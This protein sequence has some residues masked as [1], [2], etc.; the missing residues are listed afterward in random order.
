MFL[1]S[2]SMVAAILT[3]LPLISGFRVGQWI[4]TARWLTS[5]LSSILRF[6]CRTRSSSLVRWIS[7]FARQTGHVPWFR[8][9]L[10]N[11][12]DFVYGF[13][14]VR[15]ISSPHKIRSSSHSKAGHS[16]E[17][18]QSISESCE[19][20]SS[21]RQSKSNSRRSFSGGQVVHSARR[22]RSVGMAV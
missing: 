1:P 11:R 7:R 12:F 4:K 13:F 16:S 5:L 9:V 10:S 3:T 20:W 22:C 18:A 8:H 15:L 14:F 6:S 19:P 21:I 2:C 17:K